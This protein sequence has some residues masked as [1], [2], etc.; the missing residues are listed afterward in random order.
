MKVTKEEL[1][2]YEDLASDKWKERLLIRS[3]GNIYNQ[4]LLASIIANNGEEEA[5]NWAKNMVSN[6]ARSPKGNDRD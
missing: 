4:S 1:S 5:I 3:S 2:S 6:M